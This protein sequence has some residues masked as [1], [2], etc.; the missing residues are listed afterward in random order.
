[1]KMECSLSKEDEYIEYF[2]KNTN[3]PRVLAKLF[4]TDSLCY[5]YD[6]GTSKVLNCSELEYKI[7]KKII[8]GKI[9]E[10]ANLKNEINEEEYFEAMAN[11]KDSIEQEDILK[12]GNEF[13]FVSPGHFEELD[14]ELDNK[15]RQIVLELTGK[16]NLRCSYCIYSNDYTERR[17]FNENDMTEDVAKRAID[18]IN[19]HGDKEKGVAV[20]FYGGEALIKFDL[21]KKCVDYARKTITDKEVTFSVT[22]NLTLMTKEIAEYIASVKGFSLTASIDGPQEI[23]DSSRRDINGKGSFERAI[24]GLRYVVDAFGEDTENRLTL[25]MVFN[26]PF[27]FEKIK[28]IDNFF[29]SLDWLPEKINKNVTYPTVSDV[30]YDE[31]EKM[32]EKTGGVTDYLRI[33]SAETY[34]NKVKNSE[35]KEFFLRGAV[36]SPFIRIHN[37]PILI[38][39]IKDNNLNACCIPGGRKIYVSTNGDFLVCERIDGSPVIGNVYDGIN[40]KKIKELLVEDYA[41]KSINDCKNCWASRLCQICYAMSFKDQKVNMRKKR[42]YCNFVRENMEKYLILYH[43]CLEINPKELEYLNKI[44]VE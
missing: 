13:K 15:V 2:K 19:L 10:I 16:C 25:S 23:H 43:K 22:S 34:L 8:T 24:R 9:D 38:K 17:N 1:M 41:N 6:T 18:Y 28:K 39:H 40:K 44:K 3:S 11:I 37:R 36:E 33:W 32:I 7:L 26:R 14:D 21:L 12:G 29:K 35:D 27:S 5:I 4:K 20:T 31:V 30:N 42:Y